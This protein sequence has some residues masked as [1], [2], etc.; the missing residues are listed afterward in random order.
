MMWIYS[1]LCELSM[2]SSSALDSLSSRSANTVRFAGRRCAYSF[3]ETQ[4]LASDGIRHKHRN[5]LV[6]CPSCLDE[7]SPICLS[8]LLFGIGVLLSLAFPITPWPPTRSLHVE[9]ALATLGRDVVV[10]YTRDRC[11][12]WALVQVLNELFQ[13]VGAA[14]SLALD[15][16]RVN[17]AAVADMLVVSYC[18]I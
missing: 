9:A 17:I 2:Q 12:G 10:L 3:L 6:T 18:P 14:L 13:L 5:E 15:L 7:L 16:R 4:W 1:R 11:C 8:A